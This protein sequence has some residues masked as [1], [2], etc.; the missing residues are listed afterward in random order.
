MIEEG[1]IVTIIMMGSRF[2]AALLQDA[3]RQ[4]QGERLLQ[5]L[6]GELK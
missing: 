1:D 2:S 3:E 4:W 5:Y 6:K